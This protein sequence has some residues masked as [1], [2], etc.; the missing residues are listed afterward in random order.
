MKIR[1]SLS[2][3]LTIFLITV[4]QQ[5]SVSQNFPITDLDD[6][7]NKAMNDFKVPGMAV[8]VVKNDS[9]VYQK[10]FGVKNIRANEPIDEYTI[11]G[12]GSVTKT[13]TAGL[14][15]IL[16][17]KGIIDWDDK[18]IDYLP[19]FRLYNQYVT[20][21]V[22]I[23]D[24]LSH[25]VGIES[26]DILWL[27]SIFSRDE[28][29]SKAR[30]LDP[31][32]S[33]RSG[34]RYNNIM[35]LTAGQAMEKI[36]GESWDTLINERIFQPLGMSS[37]ST[38]I[39]ALEKERNVAT[40]HIYEGDQLVPISWGNIDNI[41]PAGS[42][43]SNLVDMLKWVNLHLNEGS[44]AGR[45]IWNSG[46]QKEMH[47]SH[48]ISSNSL[49]GATHFR[50]YGLGWNVWD[51][52]GKMIIWHNGICDG[53]YALISL[54]PEEKLG[55]VILQNVFH[56][57]FSLPLMLRILDAYLEI[58]E[59]E[60]WDVGEPSPL[61]KKP[62]KEEPTFYDINKLSCP[63]EQ[64]I[65]RYT[66]QMLG[67][68][69]VVIK[70]NKLLLQFDAYPMAILNHKDNDTFIADF[71]DDL[72]FM[73]SRYVSVDPIEVKFGINKEKQIKEINVSRF[74]VF[75]R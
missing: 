51:F 19:D 22:T 8:G 7:V 23:R 54:L 32:I 44:K 45:E 15:G 2:V 5:P 29:V 68:L 58:P 38:S 26:G 1:N 4:L 10:G 73:F 21:E 60:W 56:P 25:R 39:S 24:I 50:T 47:S 57:R 75:K 36:T 30:F 59:E 27:G 52:R 46:I 20:D 70:D 40:P 62:P 65:G 9:V 14:A 49:Y 53:M 12:I 16:V 67:G 64:Y 37:S 6:Y 13:F 17:N 66:N 41:G 72:P 33:F 69:S 71:G 35:V 11:F 74:G 18:V 55:I 28:I 61:G 42:I 34:F 31:S 63:L 48:T 3:V 43:N